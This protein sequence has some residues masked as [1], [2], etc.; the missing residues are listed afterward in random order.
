MASSQVAAFQLPIAGRVWVPGNSQKARQRQGRTRED[1]FADVWSEVSALLEVNPGLEAKT[2]FNHLQ[3]SYPGKFAD[4]QLR[5][6][7]RRIKV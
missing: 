6:L 7:Q 3:T 4:G 1:P 2:V 5:T